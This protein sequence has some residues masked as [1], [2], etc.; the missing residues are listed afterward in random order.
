MLLSLNTEFLGEKTCLAQ[1]GCV[2]LALGEVGAGVAWEWKAK[3]HTTKTHPGEEM[4]ILKEGVQ[5][6]QTAPEGVY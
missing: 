3:S 6:G 5:V 2:H 1:L 4:T